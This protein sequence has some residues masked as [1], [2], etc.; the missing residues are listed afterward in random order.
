MKTRARGGNCATDHSSAASD[1]CVRF[2]AAIRLTMGC[3]NLHVLSGEHAVLG[4]IDGKVVTCGSDTAAVTGQLISAARRT[5]A[6]PVDNCPPAPEYPICYAQSASEPQDESR[7]SPY[8]DA[9]RKLAEKPSFDLV[10]KCNVSASGS[11]IAE[12]PGLL[13]TLSDAP[14]LDLTSHLATKVDRIICNMTG[15]PRVAGARSETGSGT[16][17]LDGPAC[18]KLMRGAQ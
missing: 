12:R 14:Q 15:L 16:K 18:F 2:G 4:M 10:Q 7:P 11:L 5:S 6:S 3:R 17:A 8:L 1:P 9:I 13:E